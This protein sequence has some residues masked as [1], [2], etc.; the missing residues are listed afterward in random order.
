MYAKLR[1]FGERM[2]DL[3][4]NDK[5]QCPC[6]EYHNQSIYRNGFFEE[7]FVVYYRM[8]NSGVIPHKFTFMCILKD[9][10]GL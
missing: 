7:A 1:D 8:L 5:F 3:R 4:Q 2:L 6:G 9:C 10:A